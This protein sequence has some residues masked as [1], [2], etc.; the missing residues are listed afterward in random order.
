MYQTYNNTPMSI[1]AM[2]NQ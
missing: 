1:V 2:C